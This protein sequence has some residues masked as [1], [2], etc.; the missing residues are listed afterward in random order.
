MIELFGSLF[1]LLLVCLCFASEKRFL[2]SFVP[3]ASLLAWAT[4]K[5]FHICRLD[6]S[7]EI[8]TIFGAQCRFSGVGSKH[9]IMHLP[10]TL[11][12]LF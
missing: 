12:M 9:Y 8:F 1:C 5:I 4:S 10:I 6:V 3:N 11:Y 2:P 7:A